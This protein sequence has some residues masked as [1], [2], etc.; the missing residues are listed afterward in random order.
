M[1]ES[2]VEYR[3][4]TPFSRAWQATRS[5]PSKTSIV[6]EVRRTSRLRPISIDGTE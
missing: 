3:P 4:R 5:P 6:R 1:C 2:T